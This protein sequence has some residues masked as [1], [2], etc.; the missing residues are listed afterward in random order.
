MKKYQLGELMRFLK[1]RKLL[2]LL[3]IDFGYNGKYDRKSMAFA[4]FL[5]VLLG[6]GSVESLGNEMKAPYL[7]HLC[8]FNTVP[9]QSTFSRYLKR[10]DY[11]KMRE[12]NRRLI[13]RIKRNHKTNIYALDSSYLEIYGKLYTFVG[14]VYSYIAKKKIKGYKLIS[15]IDVY[16]G[17]I[18]K[19]K[20]VSCN[21][22]ECT[23]LK[24]LVDELIKDGLKPDVLLFD[25]GFY[26]GEHFEYL[27]EK[28]IIY[29][30]PM[31]KYSTNVKQVECIDLEEDK[32]LEKKIVGDL[33][34]I[35]KDVE[36]KQRAIM[37]QK[38]ERKYT[39]LTNGFDL[40]QETVV[41]YYSMRWNIENHFKVLKYDWNIR[42]YPN[43]WKKNWQKRNKRHKIFYIQKPRWKN[44]FQI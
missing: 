27:A 15:I 29:V 6:F 33:E 44:N 40:K 41:E 13:K 17:I 39:L 22:H 4:F 18:V 25:K 5:L 36:K 11:Q 26:K 8:D 28:D 23:F 16:S 12:Q 21:L 10:V 30:C 3:S 9:D 19:W 34:I 24:E 1:K 2:F 42:K 35:I 20:F 14:R 43:I 7:R 38:G 32:G 31:K 37:I